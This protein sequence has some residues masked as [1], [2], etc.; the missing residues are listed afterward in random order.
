MDA[1]VLAALAFARLASPEAGL[2]RRW[3]DG[4][5][6]AGLVVAGLT[7][8]GF[9]VTVTRY[10]DLGWRATFYA[11]G[12]P[13]RARWAVASAFAATGPTAVRDAA[14]GVARTLLR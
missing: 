1:L 7:R 2:V 10:D 4:W 14:W 9:G 12:R 5:G 11:A 8:Q 3:L 13:H 6:G